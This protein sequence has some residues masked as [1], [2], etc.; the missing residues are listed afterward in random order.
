MGRVGL[1]IDSTA[2]LDPS[3]YAEHG[4]VL[5]P[6]TV[7]F[8]QEAYLDWVEMRP[9]EFYKRLAASEQ[10]PKTSQPSV[11]QFVEAYEG[12]SEDCDSIISMHLSAA[13]SGTV[14]SAEIAARQVDV[15]V[16]VLDTRLASL[17]MALVLDEVLQARQGGASH[18]EL[19]SLMEARC[20]DVTTL[21][22]VD[23]LRYLELGGR[24]G[25]ASALLGSLLKIRP[26]LQLGADG[27]VAPYKKVKGTERVFSELAD[28]VKTIAAGKKIK[29]ALVH[30]AKPQTLSRLKDLLAAEGVDFDVAFESYVGSVIGTY[31]GPGAFGAIFLPAKAR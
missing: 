2:D 19:L 29:L 31:L 16:A 18:L 24:I 21:F 3:F 20:A 9:E 14:Q 22:Y 26:I 11:N 6:L 12:L 15:P 30:A 17:G 7:R 8:G 13:L 1:V 5:V 4:V 27:V 10:L 25:K 23:T 28:A